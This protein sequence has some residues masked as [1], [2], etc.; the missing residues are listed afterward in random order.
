M[1]HGKFGVNMMLNIYKN[2]KVLIT[3]HTGFKG[4]WL[5][6]WLTLMGA[7][8]FG[9]SL[10]PNTNPSLYNVLALKNKIN[11]IFADVRDMAKL[12]KVFD[13]FKPEIVFHLAAQP[14]VRLSY[15]EPLMTYETNVIGTLNVLECAR[16][17][18]SVLAFVN[19]TSDKCY[20]N[21]E[22]NYA[23]KED[24]KL[25]GY[26]MY[27]SSKA[28][29]EILTSSYR[30]SFLVEKNGFAL[31]S[32]R[33]GNVIGGGDWALD[34]LIPDCVRAI[35]GGNKIE[36]R[37]PNA[38]RPWQ[39]VLEPLY[40][41]LVL[42]AN[43]LNFG[44]KYAES[45]N[46]G[47]NSNGVMTVG[48][49]VQK[50]VDNWGAGDVVVNKNIDFHEAKL[51]QLDVRKADLVLNWKPKY[52]VDEA[53]FKTVEWYKNFYDNSNDMFDFTLSQIKEYEQK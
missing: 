10:E 47:P 12:S 7:E 37:N 51:L 19:V 45:F 28:C 38:I 49:I 17:T 46:F 35:A 34:R 43:L 24:D 32:A 15:L 18:E 44:N 50:I 41:Y 3:G 1:L 27:S 25:G 40:G 53:V 39:H 42:G 26:D 8:V 13:D 31:A 48:Q 33:A 9:Y 22:A 30:K 16:K 21:I 4:A 52:N 5:S 29:S 36:I 23:Y 20:E 2:K 11:D 14:L 6:L